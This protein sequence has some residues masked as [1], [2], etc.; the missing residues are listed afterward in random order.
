MR[1]T[2]PAT[3]SSG[4]SGTISKIIR[5][6]GLVFSPALENAL[7]QHGMTCTLRPK[8]QGT[9][10]LPSLPPAL[11]VLRTGFSAPSR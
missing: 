5:I 8:I 11:A 1:Y 4:T 2:D 6:C 9:P 10:S 3:G 7:F